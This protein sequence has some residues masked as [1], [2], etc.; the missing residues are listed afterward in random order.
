VNWEVPFNG[1]VYSRF[2]R[3]SDCTAAG[4]GSVI[5]GCL[6]TTEVPTSFCGVDWYNSLDGVK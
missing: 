2:G 6:I 4:L 5:V 1:R 3:M